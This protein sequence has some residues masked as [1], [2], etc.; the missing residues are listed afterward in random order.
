MSCPIV[1]IF[2]ACYNYSYVLNCIVFI[3]FSL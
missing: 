1:F 2:F 3:L